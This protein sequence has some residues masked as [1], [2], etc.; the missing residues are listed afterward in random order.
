M[1]WGQLPLL[2]ES[3][4][5]DRESEKRMDGSSRELVSQARSAAARASFE[6]RADLLREL[7]RAV[8]DAVK[9][10]P[11]REPAPEG[12]SWELDQLSEVGNAAE[13]F[14][15]VVLESVYRGAGR[16]ESSSD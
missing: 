11:L 8:R 7:V 16:Q 5:D 2:S 6:E 14:Y 1:K 15:D 10:D 3:H 4:I 9:F 13:D 12:T